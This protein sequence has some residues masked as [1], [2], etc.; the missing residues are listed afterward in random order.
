MAWKKLK[1]VS[2]TCMGTI[3]DS[4][5]ESIKTL[6]FQTIKEMHC[7]YSAGRSQLLSKAKVIVSAVI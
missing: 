1:T 3:T 2:F 6:D 5:L 4:V 7:W